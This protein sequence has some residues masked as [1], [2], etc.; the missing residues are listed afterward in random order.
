MES[1]GFYLLETGLLSFRIMTLRF[2]PHFVIQWPFI[3]GQ[4]S[5]V[6]MYQISYLLMPMEGHLGGFQLLANM[7][8]TIISIGVLVFIRT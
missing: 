1:Y 5:I 6:W 4:Y 8:G 7:N 2:H 3:A